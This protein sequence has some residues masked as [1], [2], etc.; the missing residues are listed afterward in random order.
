MLHQAK[1]QPCF[2]ALPHL[3]QLKTSGEHT[4]IIKLGD[5][6]L[7]ELTGGLHIRYIRQD[8]SVGHAFIP[9]FVLRVCLAGERGGWASRVAA[10]AGW[11]SCALPP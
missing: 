11:R 1:R 9:P 6:R 4:R 5:E 2:P 7:L 8:G 10:V 3:L